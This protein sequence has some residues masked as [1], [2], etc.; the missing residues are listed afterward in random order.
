MDYF[1]ENFGEILRKTYEHFSIL[2]ISLFFAIIIG[3][4]IGIYISSRERLAN[5]IISISSILFTIPS[6]ALF[7][8]LIVIL[9]PLKLGIGKIPTI[10]P[11]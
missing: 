5:F 3:V 9:S 11:L 1:I 4:S 8:L 10:L 2:S 7:G 6:L